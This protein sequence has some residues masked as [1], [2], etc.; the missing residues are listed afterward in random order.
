MVKLAHVNFIYGANGSGKSTIARIIADEARYPTS[1]IKWKEGTKLQTMVYNQDFVDR[2][3][4]QLAEFKGIFTLGEKENENL[5]K[6]AEVKGRIAN[7]SSQ[8]VSLKDSLEG[9]EGKVGKRQEHANL[10]A[11]FKEKCWK[12]KQKHD[13]KLQGAFKGFRNDT[14]KFK[15]KVLAELDINTA[16]LFTQIEL[17]EK[18][19]IVF[20]EEPTLDPHIPQIEFQSLIAHQSNAILKKPVIG[21]KDV[22]IAAMITKLSNSDWVKQGRHFYDKNDRICPFCQ[23]ETTN[24]FARSLTE[25]FDE[26]FIDDT[27][28]IEGVHKAYLDECYQIQKHLLAIIANPSRFIELE[29]LKTDKELLDSKIAINIQLLE[30]KKAEPSQ[31][32]TLEPLDSILDAIQASIASANSKILAHNQIVTNLE[33]EQNLLTSQVWRF[34]IEELMSDIQTYRKSKAGLETAI[35]SLT[36]QMTNKTSERLREESDLRNL[37]K[38][39]TSVQPTIDDINA[40]LTSFGFQGFSLAISTDGMSYRLL[41]RNG[42]SAKTTLSEGERTFIT[43][44]Y[45]YHLVKGSNSGSGVTNDRIVVFDDPVSS[46]DSE[47]LFIVSSL[48]RKL[49]EDVNT[50]SASIKQIFVFTHNVYFHKEV[51]FK[52]NREKRKQAFFIIR[53]VNEISKI[54]PYQ[55]NPIRTSYDLLWEE[56]RRPD[57]AKLTIQNTLR[58]ILENY[59]KILGDIDSDRICEMFTGRDKLVC[60]SLFSWVNDGSHSASD[61]IHYST[62]DEEMEKYLEVFKR[63]FKESKNEAHYIMMMREAYTEEA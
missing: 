7:L 18:A 11:D 15:D 23:Q 29:K 46:L 20:G 10:E 28:A 25:Y 9:S 30:K 22:D 35:S 24:S 56:V 57:K 34:V 37:E 26:T 19:A 17:E 8:L 45:F 1:T 4:N 52:T 21:K 14:Q 50:S 39:S 53:K 16:N 62:H 5:S 27:H 47:I 3:F 60:K 54:E 51:S 12:Q 63:I 49:F 61:D 31:I 44:L 38:E 43:F 42:E 55:S 40:I 41:R 2:N 13:E 32:T 59:F 6:I 58:R 48:I 36:E 33:K